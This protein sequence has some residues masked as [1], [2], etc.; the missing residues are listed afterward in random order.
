[1]GNVFKYIPNEYRGEK[2][3]MQPGEHV[4]V[5][6]EVMN[7]GEYHTNSPDFRFGGQLMIPEGYKVLTF[8][9]GEIFNENG[10]FS[11]PT[12]FATIDVWLVNTEK[13]EV[14]SV[15][16]EINQQYDYS[17]PG[18][19]VRTKTEEGPTLGLRRY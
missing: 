17:E 4:V 7:S 18:K 6:R 13:V 16:N 3:I 19:V 10:F 14:Q 8:H 11:I 5:M 12:K 2:V 9:T 1:M 15:W